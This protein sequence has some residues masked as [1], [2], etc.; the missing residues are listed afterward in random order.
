LGNFRGARAYL[1][2]GLKTSR[3]PVALD[4]LVSWATLLKEEADRRS[5]DV[6]ASQAAPANQAQKQQA[7][8]ILSLVLNHPAAAQPYKDKAVRLLAELEAELPP[9]VVAAAKEQGQTKTIEEVVAKIV[10]Q[11]R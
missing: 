11:I 6:P 4:A 7:V 9:E 5:A 3:L 10:G 8:E 2:E 1:L